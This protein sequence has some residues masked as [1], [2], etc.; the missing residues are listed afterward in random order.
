VT[1]RGNET[2]GQNLVFQEPD[3]GQALAWLRARV[4]L[5]QRQVVER[6]RERQR[7]RPPAERETLSEVF[8]QAL[9]TGKRK[10]RQRKLEAILAA[11]GSDLA[12]L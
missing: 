10:P 9:E 3:L 7:A 6:V 12:E 8:Y 2:E 11:V 1:G 4:R 5:T